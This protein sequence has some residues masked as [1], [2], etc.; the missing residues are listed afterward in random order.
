MKEETVQTV[1]EEK[2]QGQRLDRYISEQ[3]ELFPRSQV[4][5]RVVSWEVNG[6]AA[7][8]STRL[9][10]GDRLRIRYKA[11]EPVSVEP[12][13]M[14]L[15]CIFENEDVAVI[16]KPQGMV[17]HP[18]AGHYTGT[19]VHGLLHQF[20]GLKAAFPGEEIRPG[21]V[22][23]LDKETSG[24]L[25][26]AK[27]R[28][29][30]EQ[31]SGMFAARSVEKRYIALVKGRPD[32]PRGRI[33]YPIARDPHNRKRFTWRQAGGRDAETEYRMLRSYGSHSLVLLHPLTG[34]THQ[35]RVHMASRGV[36]VLGDPLYG[37]RDARFPAASLMLHA[38]KLRL[39]LPGEGGAVS[40]R[41]QLPPRF[42]EILRELAARPAHES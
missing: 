13:A 32:P 27:H 20:P 22:H 1:V 18:G 35:L 11:P 16:D 30:L 29:A 17:V 37:R 24:I 15:R 8:P 9:N 36:P 19:L 23:R 31:L 33:T 42:A 39:E 14:P 28:S 40:F 25:I 34:R 10:R 41:S 3:L 21:I 6:A 5:K 12:E 4:K 7:K 26:V 38:F 2:A